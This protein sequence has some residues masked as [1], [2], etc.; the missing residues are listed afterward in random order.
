MVDIAMADKGKS[1]HAMKAI[2]FNI[3]FICSPIFHL[4]W[5]KADKTLFATMRRAGFPGS[6]YQGASSEDSFLTS[7]SIRRASPPYFYFFSFRPFLRTG[8]GT[9]ILVTD[10]SQCQS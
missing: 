3:F 10:A 8:K 9:I 4:N 7:S 1:K 5:L 2:A 6:P